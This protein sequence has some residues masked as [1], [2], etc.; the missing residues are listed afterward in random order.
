MKNLA[1]LRPR[2]ARLP[3]TRALQSRDREGAVGKVVS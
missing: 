2:H 3:L 1:M